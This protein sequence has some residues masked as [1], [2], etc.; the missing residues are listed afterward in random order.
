MSVLDDIFKVGEFL[1][2]TDTKTDKGKSGGATGGFSFD[3]DFGSEFDFSSSSG[4]KTDSLQ[5][6]QGADLLSILLQD[7]DLDVQHFI[8]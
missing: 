4:K 5:L 8:K 7:G 1:A 6:D 2:D 3:F